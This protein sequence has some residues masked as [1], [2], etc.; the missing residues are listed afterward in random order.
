MSRKICLGIAF[1]LIALLAAGNYWLAHLD[2]SALASL[3]VDTG[4]Y[5]SSNTFYTV[6]LP[7][8]V[9]SVLAADRTRSIP[10]QQKCRWSIG[11]V[12]LFPVSTALLAMRMLRHR[13]KAVAETDATGDIDAVIGRFFAAFDNRN[14]RAPTLAEL[15]SLFS[16]KAVVVNS[17]GGIAQVS[18]VEEFA[19]PRIELLNGGTLR[20]FHEWETA[21]TTEV[22]AG[23]ATRTSRYEKSGLQ[24]G[25]P[26]DGSGTKL[27]HLVRLD[28][29]WRISA[30]SWTDDAG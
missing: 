2:L 6:L 5:Q 8:L 24:N 15:A 11:L 26:Y 30:L 7:I 27:F 28:G 29:G 18:S 14:G 4:S 9:I 13:F 3:G 1:A 12:L 21:A 25:S 23:I 17:V 22:F 10:E 16:A 19:K 20:N